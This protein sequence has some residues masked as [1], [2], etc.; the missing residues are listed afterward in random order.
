M[1]LAD[2]DVLPFEF[3]NLAETIG[4]Y[5]EE[6]EKLKVR[7]KREK[8]VDLTPLKSAVKSL[9]EAAHRYEEALGRARS[10]NFGQVKDT[11][12]LNEL[13]YQS[14]RKLTNEHGL[15][16]REWFKHEIYAPGFYTG[17]GVKTIPGVREAIEEKKWDEVQPEVKKASDAIQALASQVDSA[18]KMLE[19]K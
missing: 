17:Y 16:R 10:T 6:I 8:D 2:A 19:G 1:R 3:T 18:A 4:R 11:R 15:P 9:G 13:L 12:A 14:E 7:P 5:V